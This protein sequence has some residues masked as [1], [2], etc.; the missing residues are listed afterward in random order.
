M[1]KG[2]Y[3]MVSK[4][5]LKDDKRLICGLHDYGEEP[6]LELR[7]YFRCLKQMNLDDSIKR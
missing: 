3:L 2:E 1:W 4:N 7:K 6:V 5:I